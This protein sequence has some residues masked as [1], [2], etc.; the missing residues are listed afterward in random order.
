MQYNESF[1]LPIFLKHYS[2]YFD[3]K[4]IFVIDHGSDQNLVPPEFN[5]I[6]LP[7][8]KPFSELDRLDCIKSI[9]KGLLKYYD[10][11][12][13]VDTDELIYLNDFNWRELE[14]SSPIYVAGFDATTAEINGRKKLVGIPV[15]FLCKASIFN[16]VP[17]W[18][19]GFHSIVN[20]A[21]PEFFK[22][23]MVHL[24]HLLEVES[25]IRHTN[26]ASI[27]ENMNTTE[28]GWGY[29]QHWRDNNQDCYDFNR[30]VVDAV[31]TNILNNFSPII[32]E[33]Y[34]IKKSLDG[35]IDSNPGD[36]IYLAKSLTWEAAKITD[37]TNYFPQLITID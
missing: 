11:G 23:P 4:N 36:F 29:A 6:Y 25:N 30:V 31:E 28:K 35:Y 22:V 34:F 33:H 8:D 32:S 16:R 27:Y 14:S 5:R 15:P 9:C 18:V 26:R 3:P 20:A 17:D 1:I 2:Q 37:L 7:R 21:P 13:F 12:I 10:A 24:K 19:A